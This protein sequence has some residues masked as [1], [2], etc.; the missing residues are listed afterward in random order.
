VRAKFVLKGTK[1]S[2]STCRHG[3]RCLSDCCVFL[4]SPGGK[5]PGPRE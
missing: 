5:A 4:I 3:P 2:Y 1:H